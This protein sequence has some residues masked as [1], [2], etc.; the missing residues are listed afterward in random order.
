MLAAGSEVSEDSLGQRQLCGAAHFV[1]QNPVTSVLIHPPAACE[2]DG[3][4]GINH[5]SGAARLLSEAAA[6]LR[7]QGS[8]PEL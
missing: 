6:R 4:G 8:G 2:D 1:F 3:P 5:K 7:L